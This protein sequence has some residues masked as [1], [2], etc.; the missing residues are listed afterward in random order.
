MCEGQE[1]PHSVGLRGNFAANP[2]KS[3]LGKNLKRCALS[4]TQGPRGKLCDSWVPNGLDTGV[5]RPPRNRFPPKNRGTG[6]RWQRKRCYLESA[7][8]P[9]IEK[10]AVY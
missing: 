10:S 1:A 8:L 7:N 5:G 9:K 6:L 4:E 2:K 3:I